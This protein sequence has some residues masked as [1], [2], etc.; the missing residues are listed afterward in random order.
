[1]RRRSMG[2]GREREGGWEKSNFEAGLG[3]GATHVRPPVARRA[4]S[5]RLTQDM[6]RNSKPYKNIYL[7]EVDTTS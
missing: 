1:M 7:V 5:G 4:A 6:P 3:T 2:I